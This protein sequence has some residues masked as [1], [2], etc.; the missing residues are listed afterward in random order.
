MSQY[1]KLYNSKGWQSRRKNQLAKEPLCAFC[2]AKGEHKLASVADHIEPHRG[3]AEKFFK[4]KLQSLCKLCH[5]ST[6]Q[7][8][9]RRGYSGA[10]GLDGWP[11]DGKHPFNKGE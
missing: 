1:P 3:N 7:I 2:M 4:G 10:V 9:E 11:I 8:E 6:K 5:D